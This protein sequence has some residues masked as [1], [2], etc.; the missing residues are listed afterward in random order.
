MDATCSQTGIQPLRC[1]CEL[2]AQIELYQ[3]KIPQRGISIVFTVAA[4]LDSVKGD[5]RNMLKGGTLMAKKRARI[6]MQV[7]VEH[8]TKDKCFGPLSHSERESCCRSLF[9]NEYVYE[10]PEKSALRS[11]APTVGAGLAGRYHRSSG[12]GC[13]ILVLVTIFRN[14]NIYLIISSFLLEVSRCSL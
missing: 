11:T 2:S 1:Y 14:L 10:P 5:A 7:D 12:Y 8:Y 6:A 9:A 13:S 4:G 3:D